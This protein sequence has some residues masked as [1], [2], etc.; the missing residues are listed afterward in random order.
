MRKKTQ[1]TL[2]CIVALAT[3]GQVQAGL[4]FNLVETGG[5]V[6]IT[7]T[8]SLDLD[9]T[10]GFELLGTNTIRAV[11]PIS[12]LL[13]V[14]DAVV[15][16]AYNIDVLGFTPFGTSGNLEPLA[17]SGA[18]VAMFTGTTGPLIGVPTGYVS[19]GL[20]SATATTGPATFASLGMTPGTYV[21]TLTNGSTPRT[22]LQ[23]TSLNRPI[24]FPN[25]PPSP[26]S[27]LVPASRG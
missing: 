4:I 24:P 8:G 9:A 16:D 11:R 3:V 20:L 18:R 1:L 10:Q 19:G 21:T 13:L 5:V 14:G 6:E 15:S 22:R 27:A 25:H 17:S 2:A 23:S 26:S 7:L 12:G